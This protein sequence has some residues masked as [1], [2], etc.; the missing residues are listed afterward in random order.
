VNLGWSWRRGREREVARRSVPGVPRFVPADATNED[1]RSIRSLHR[2][3]GGR[4]LAAATAQLPDS[5]VRVWGEVVS[6]RQGEERWFIE[7]VD[8]R[9]D[10]LIISASVPL[11]H[12]PPELGHTIGVEGQLRARRDG[13]AIVTEVRG[14][15]FVTA[16]VSRR[17]RERRALLDEVRRHVPP[18]LDLGAYDGGLVVVVTAPT[19][20]A[21]AD[22][23]R[24]LGPPPTRPPVELSA[25]HL[26]DA[27]AIARA[28]TEA[29]SRRE[30]GLVVL[31]RGGGDAGDLSAF[32]SAEVTRAVAE[33]AAHVPVIVGVGHASDWTLSDEVASR[34]ATTPTQA[35]RMVAWAWSRATSRGTR[36][37]VRRPP[38]GVLF[39]LALSALAVVALLLL[40]GGLAAHQR[41]SSLEPAAAP[42]PASPT[43]SKPQPSP[44]RR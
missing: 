15:G 18:P 23:L 38:T 35:A 8:A 27:T 20:H 22:F 25:V 44:S 24:N 21:Y 26:H 1:H 41:P 19:S 11:S 39:R 2:L 3:V 37:T 40:V 4:V 16:G 31:T 6:V 29:S 34:S 42:S 14:S 10:G 12:Q 17:A 32:S 7:L 28:V 5:V 33:A 13:P 9:Q 30:V 43:S 36:H